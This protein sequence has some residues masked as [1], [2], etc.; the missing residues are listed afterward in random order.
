MGIAQ[1]GY[2][3]INAT[4]VK[5]WE[6]F[7]MDILGLQLLEHGPDGTLYLRMDEYH[8]RL[9]IHPGGD[10]DLVCIGWQV[11]DSEALQEMGARL[12]DA[13]VRTS[14]GTPEELAER[15]VLDLIKF[16]DPNGHPM[17]LFYGPLILS[18]RPFSPGR[19]ITGFNTGPLGMGHVVLTV[20]DLE[21][22]IEFYRDVMGLRIRD[23]INLEHLVPGVGSLVFFYCNPRHHSLAIIKVP[24][25]KRMLHF[26]LEVK[27][28]D[29]VGS[30]LDLTS[31]KGIPITR[32]LGRHSNDHM[33][34]VYL[35]SP[36]GFDVEYG[37]GGRLVHDST[38]IVEQHLVPSIWGHKLTTPRPHEL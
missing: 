18:D 8:H 35:Q 10:D 2:L 38:W 28:I 34:S 5:Q 29:D 1:L 26:M 27:S 3:R 7:A 6:Q 24:S 13:G 33:I 36:S 16:V 37:W 31:E 4:D 22:S 11:P 17:E 25:S 30:V 23:Y 15:K 9:V 20:K 32:N 14:R 12:E 19:A 21:K